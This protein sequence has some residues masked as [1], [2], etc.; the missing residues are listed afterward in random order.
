ML[1]MAIKAISVAGMGRFFMDKKEIDKMAIADEEASKSFVT[2]TSVSISS[3]SPKMDFPL[4]R[5]SLSAS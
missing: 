1:A 4:C 5:Y 3:Q 2:F